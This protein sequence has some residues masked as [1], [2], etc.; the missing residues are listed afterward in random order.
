MD[1]EAFKS[2]KRLF[3]EACELGPQESHA[4]LDEA[5][6]GDRQLRDEVESLLRHDAQL[7]TSVS[8]D[9]TE[10][11]VAVRRT[12]GGPRP[13]LP[14]YELIAVIGRGGLGEVWL[15]RNRI[16]EQYCAVKVF[17]AG[18]F[19]ELEG[20]R[21]YKRRV[22]EHPHLVPIE[23]VGQVE[24]TCYYV[25]PLADDACASSP[26]IDP[27]QYEPLTLAG[28]IE[29]Q[30]K[31]PLEE[32]L[33]IGRQMLSA[34]G[35]LHGRGA[36]HGDVKPANILKVRG[37]WQLA[38]Q[39]L[40]SS[41]EAGEVSGW[42]P[43]YCPPE[44]AGG[45]EADLYALGVVLFE[46]ASGQ[47]VGQLGEFLDPTSRAGDPDPRREQLADVLRRACAEDAARRFMRAGEMLES[48][49]AIAVSDKETAAA[50][51]PP[52][53]RWAA[54]FVLL[55]GAAAALVVGLRPGRSVGLPDAAPGG[56]Q[57][58]RIVSVR[59][60]HYR[61]WQDEAS[62]I[63]EIGLDST[64]ARFRE[65]SVAINVE[66]SQDAYGY[67]LAL[68]PDGRVQ[69]CYPADAETPPDAARLLDAPVLPDG[70][71]GL[72]ALTDGVGA[73]AFAVVA[74]RTPLPP[75]RQ[76]EQGLGAIPW[77]PFEIEGV[78]RSD[79]DRLEH[80]GQL[81]GEIVARPGALRPFTSSVAA[82]RNSSGIETVLAVA[83]P[84][85][86]GTAADQKQEQEP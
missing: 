80:L 32:V 19:V 40:L 51:W 23:H 79:G 46:T 22:A 86:Q 3:L 83:F 6:P 2:V 68:N 63:G 75:Y 35:H 64:E 73:Q 36:R 4:F 66:F 76:W 39:G 25:M 55:L 60:A 9:R 44:G 8:D 78:W 45:P 11:T 34:L 56:A 20:V 71:R 61:G 18:S 48:L 85:R 28:H 29:R 15:G 16:D 50:R 72:F 70:S 14:D 31:L 10:A 37:R 30:G 27:L 57:P 52:A 53:W 21:Q 1:A 54:G 17:S 13:E 82:L 24:D 62:L 47:G 77:T 59:L 33:R 81:R 69:L 65:D 43:G 74:S 84:I 49:E 7:P 41:S 26:V 42:T 12:G 38:D 58:L 5:C 67:V